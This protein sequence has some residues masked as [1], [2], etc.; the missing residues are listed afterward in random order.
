MF[1]EEVVPGLKSGEITIENS[2]VLQE[3]QESLGL[4]PDECERIFENLIVKLATGQFNIIKGEL[5]RG[6]QDT[7]VDPLK[8]LVRY[9]KFAEGDLG[10]GVEDEATGWEIFNVFETIDFSE[11]DA[12]EVDNQKK[13]LKVALSLP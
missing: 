7:C 10:L 13:L 12:D 3:I 6:R 4:D 1:E 9:A 11:L 8:Q 5:M 2:D